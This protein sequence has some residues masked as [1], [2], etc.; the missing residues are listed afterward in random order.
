MNIKEVNSNTMSVVIESIMKENEALKSK[1][2]SGELKG[3]IVIDFNEAYVSR[4]DANILLPLLKRLEKY[5]DITYLNH[6]IT[7]Y[8][9]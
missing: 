3:K 8:N 7:A 4:A 6:E 2:E 5:N 1:L 9:D